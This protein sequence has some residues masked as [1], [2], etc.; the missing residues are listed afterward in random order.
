MRSIEVGRPTLNW[1]ETIPSAR[2]DSR[3]SKK[4]EGEL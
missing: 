2:E 4:G 3:T 1:V